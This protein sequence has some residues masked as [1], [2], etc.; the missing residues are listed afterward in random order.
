[1]ATFAV[2]VILEKGGYIDGETTQSIA[3]QNTIA[4]VLVI[5]TGGLLVI[6]GAFAMTL[7]LNCETHSTIV[8]E[9][10]RL[11]AGGVKS[12]ATPKVCAVVEALTGFDYDDV[13]D[14]KNVPTVETA[15]ARVDIEE[16]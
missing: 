10:D 2:G 16:D 13:W 14:D 12:D 3:T 5:R 11:K 7:Q 8:Y 9:I 1:M 4:G 6:A 15:Q